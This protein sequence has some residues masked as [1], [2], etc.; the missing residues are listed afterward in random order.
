MFA[1]TGSGVT[2]L[3][4]LTVRIQP[5]SAAVI[6]VITAALFWASGGQALAGAW[7][8][9]SGR[10]QVITKVE[11]QSA[12]KGF[13]PEGTLVGIGGRKDAT[14]SIHVEHGLSDRLTLQARAGLTRGRDPF[15]DYEGRGPVEVGLRYAFLKRPQ[16]IA[17]VYLG[18]GEAGAGRNAGY[19]VPGEGG[20]ELEARLLLGR[21]KATRFGSFFSDVQ[22]AHLRRSGLADET[23]VDATL[24]FRPTGNWLLLAQT[25]AGEAQSRP[26][27]S[28][29]LKA[30]VSV[31]RH[32]GPWSLQAGWRETLDGRETAADRGAVVGIW[33]HF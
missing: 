32:F 1:E 33:R 9:E 21:S 3:R 22:I 2:R 15:V 26:V 5:E 30:E 8:M 25:Y 31:V 23:R 13:S 18:A 16:T 14:A 7:P 10:T 29:W 17:A 28:R 24:G 4:R 20:L 27:K 11:L 19:A 6:L 12:S